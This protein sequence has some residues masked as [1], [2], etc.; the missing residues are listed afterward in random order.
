MFLDHQLIFSDAQALTAA[1][2]STNYVD[3]SVARDIGTGQSLY[4]FVSVDVA[5]TDAGSN[6]TVSVD[7]YYDSTTTFTPDDT[8]RMFIIPATAAAGSLYFARINPIL[9][10]NYRYAELYY[11]MN[12]G[13][14]TTGTVTA[15]IVMGVQKNFSYPDGITIS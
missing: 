14:L 8:Q 4:V 3:L 5:L 6:S 13:D 9:V 10:T 1:A 12:N 15:G 11:T 2:A 7:L